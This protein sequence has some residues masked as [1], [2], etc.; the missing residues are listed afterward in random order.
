MGKSF[1]LSISSGDQEDDHNVKNVT[2][3]GV[4][5]TWNS[6]W[7]VNITAKAKS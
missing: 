7:L 6:N 2:K 5:D 4:K 1:P 3:E